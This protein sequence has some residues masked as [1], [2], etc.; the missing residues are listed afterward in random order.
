MEPASDGTLRNKHN[1]MAALRQEED[2][3]RNANQKK[4]DE[5][6]EKYRKSKFD[7]F[8]ASVKKVEKERQAEIAAS[9]GALTARQH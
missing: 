6:F 2:S 9:M 3:Q 5:R 1:E 4:E 8:E 7:E